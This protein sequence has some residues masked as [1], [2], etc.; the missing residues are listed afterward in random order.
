MFLTPGVRLGAF[1]ILSPLGAGGMGE[2]Y[3]ARDTRLD[4]TVAI[5]VLPQHLA[6]DPDLCGRFEREARAI[7]ALEHP[8]ICV[9]HDLGQQ[10]D[11]HFLVMELLEGQTIAERLKKGP[12]PIDQV[13]TCAIQTAE[14]LD[15]AHRQGIVHR[16]LKPSNIMLTKSGVKLLDFGL[17]KLRP[18]VA[19]AG[20]ERT[21]LTQTTPITRQGAVLGTFQYMAPEQLE[22]HEA[23]KRTDIF[24]FGAVVYEMAT[25]RRA[26]EG[27]SQAAVTAAILDRDPPPVAD[28]QPLAPPALERVVRRCLAKDPDERWQDVG[29]VAVELRWIGEPP[30]GALQRPAPARRSRAG[31]AVIALGGLIV[32]AVAAGL[33][34]WGVMRSQLSE[35]EVAIQSVVVPLPPEAPL[36]LTHV[37]PLG[38]GRPSMALSPAGT[39]LVYVGERGGTSQLYLR[40]MA[41]AEVKAISGTEGG[42]N[43]FF[44]PDGRWIGFF[45]ENKLKKTSLLGG[46]PVTL[47][48]ARNPY[49][50][51]WAPDDTIVFADSEGWSLLRVSADGGTPRLVSRS[52]AGTVSARFL[53][54]DVLPGGDHVLVRNG[55]G[56]TVLVAVKT[57]EARVLLEDATGARYVPTGH[58]VFARAGSLHAAPFDLARLELTG[59]AVPLVQGVR[60]E[61]SLGAAQFTFSAN[62]TLAYVPGGPILAK[63]VWVDRKGSAES[64]P[65]PPRIY[66]AFKLS[67]DGR[68]I[69]MQVNGPD[70]DIWVYEFARGTFVRLTFDGNSTIPMWTPDGRRITFAST[71]PGASGLYWQAFDGS[72]EAEQILATD[73]GSVPVSWSPDGRVLAFYVRSEIST[74][75]SLLHR[76]NGRKVVAPFVSTRF[77]EWGPVFSPDGRWIAYTSDESGAYEVYIR[78]YPSPGGKWQISVDGG[79]EPRWSS[80]GRELFYRNGQR[81]MVAAV[82]AT[83]DEFAA[84]APRVLF[85]GPYINP[86]GPSYDV[87]PDGGRLLVIKPSEEQT[88]PTQLQLVINW[89]ED[90]KRRLPTS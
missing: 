43:P 6:S 12:L 72:S 82:T 14:A 77:A 33:V 20:T 11:L 29:D 38:I 31:S 76:D 54:P 8:H 4:R 37:V 74:D 21:A 78:P 40:M 13:L 56:A 79:E 63:L 47:C 7:A 75:I 65:M 86:P 51:S 62:G 22:G 45:A 69:A 59:P 35:G 28:F 24:A 49:G 58:L 32:G 19:G 64:I 36:G 67:P 90:L 26:F 85:E 80:D 88:G 71:K 1:E 60:T 27:N 73:Q 48:D 89:F 25:G 50:A 39:H 44:S 42:F 57:G 34:T 83:T 10:D 2:V 52:K 17:A 68:R 5:K 18:A 81:W 53:W 46:D 70:P 3:K 30:T 9:I 23:D 61:A 41:Q 55:R 15:K 16:D 66:G 87:T 84:A